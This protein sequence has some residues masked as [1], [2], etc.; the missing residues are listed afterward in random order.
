MTTEIKKALLPRI[1]A[2]RI[3]ELRGSLGK[4]NEFI[5][6]LWMR[7]G[8]GVPMATSELRQVTF[9]TLMVALIVGYDREMT[10]EEKRELAHTEIYQ[11]LVHGP[12]RY[13]TTAE[14]EA[15]ADGILYAVNTLGIE[16]SG[17]NN[18]E[19]GAQ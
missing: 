17:I 5:A 12:L 6:E 2:D 13:R 18:G 3:E 4:S 16:I 10:E 14:Q 1:V 19:V 9:D 8:G 11:E 15:Y 7:T